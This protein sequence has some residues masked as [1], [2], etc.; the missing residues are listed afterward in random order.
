MRYDCHSILKKNEKTKRYLGN[1]RN[2]FDEITFDRK[3]VSDGRKK[4]SPLQIQGFSILRIVAKRLSSSVASEIISYT[5]SQYWDSSFMDFCD[6][7]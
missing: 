3:A 4:P 6:M 1:S 7:H 2:R 5:S